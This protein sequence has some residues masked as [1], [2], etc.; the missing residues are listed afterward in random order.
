M[1]LHQGEVRVVERIIF[2]RGCACVSWSQGTSA[3]AYTVALVC[4]GQVFGLQADIVEKYVL[5]ERIDTRGCYTEE[6]REGLVELFLR[7]RSGFQQRTVGQLT[8][9]P[10]PQVVEEIVQVVQLNLRKALSDRIVEQIVDEPVLQISKR[11]SSW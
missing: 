1:A 2:A 6:N 7:V 10:V 11:S 3:V 4:V 5:G 8:E 9:V